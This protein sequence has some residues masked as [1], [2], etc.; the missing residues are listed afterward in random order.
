MSSTPVKLQRVSLLSFDAED[1]LV[2][3]LI[4]VVAQVIRTDF[5]LLWVRLCCHSLPACPTACFRAFS[6][7]GDYGAHAISLQQFLRELLEHAFCKN[8]CYGFPG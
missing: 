8:A 5:T 7:S 6:Q 1:G 4:A 3:S 2:A